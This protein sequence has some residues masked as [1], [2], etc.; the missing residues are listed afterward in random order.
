V[1]GRFFL[2]AAGNSLQGGLL[3]LLAAGNSLQ[4]GLLGLLAA[5]NSL[6]GGRLGLLA[7]GNRQD[8]SLQDGLLSLLAVQS[9]QICFLATSTAFWFNSMYRPP[10]ITVKT[11]K[12]TGSWGA[13]D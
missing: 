10:K 11:T 7:A 4:G 9:S 6:Q 3:G 13:A 5:G 2:L 12:L 8:S 1:A